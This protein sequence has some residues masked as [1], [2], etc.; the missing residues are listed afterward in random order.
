MI[1]DPQ[2]EAKICEM[3]R[4]CTVPSKQKIHVIQILPILIIMGCFTT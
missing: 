3:S 4:Q 1:H 2:D